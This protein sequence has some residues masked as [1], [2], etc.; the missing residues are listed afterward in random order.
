M[1]FIYKITRAT[2]GPS[3]LAKV[4][5]LFKKSSATGVGYCR[6]YKVGATVPSYSVMAVGATNLTFSVVVEGDYGVYIVQFKDDVKEV[7]LSNL[8]VN[9]FTAGS[10]DNYS[11][12]VDSSLTGVTFK[13]VNNGSSNLMYSIDNGATFKTT[14]G[15]SC[16]FTNAEILSAGQE[17]FISQ[18][19]VKKAIGCPGVEHILGS[20][21]VLGDIAYSDM[22]VTPTNTQ[23]T[24]I[25]GN[26]GTI[27]LA[28]TG[29]SGN[30][31]YS[32]ADGPTVQN[33]SGLVAG[34]YVVTVTDITTLEVVVLNIA[35]TDPITVTEEGSFIEI[36]TMNSIT[37]VVTSVIDGCT[38]PQGLDNV[39][40]CEQVYEGFDRV[41]YFQ[42]F[43]KC[44]IPVTQI[45][46]DFNFFTVSLLKYSDNSFVKA[47]IAELKEQNIGVTEDF[48]ITIRD[49]TEAN[50]SRVYFNAGA[51]PIPLSAGNVFEILNNANGYNG[52]YAILDIITDPTLGYQYLVITK[53]FTG[54]G[55]YQTGTGRFLS[56]TADFN[57][58]EVV[59]D[60]SD[61]DEGEYYL[62]VYAQ[63]ET[64]L[65]EIFAYSEPLDIRNS[66]PGT[67]LVKYRNVDNAFDITWTTGYQGLI[68]VPSHFGHRRSPG[69]ERTVNRN[70]DYK[71]VKV[72]AKK[73]RVL[74]FQVWSLPPY[75]HEKLSTIFDCDNYTL[76][77]I[78]CQT[79][80][81]YGE[82]EYKD[83]F[84]LADS[85]IKIEAAWYDRY[86]S[87]DLGSVSDGGFL[88]TET[89]FIK[90]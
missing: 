52:N 12:E 70:S 65:I 73:T 11:M 8:E 87:N 32:W 90:R 54:P 29:G 50:K 62:Q 16:F 24:F 14:A 5:L 78:E 13:N 34:D 84:L 10:C 6:I 64:S 89:G 33:R 31:T 55:L 66:Q 1:R 48:G 82:P 43:N 85:S 9:S 63:N 19:I 59:H 58:F 28:I 27:T 40:L 71:L 47:F 72:S 30:R 3:F 83:R 39:L 38:N 44:D 21:I 81:G 41:N 36:P 75:M 26:D 2:T 60:F 25:G 18:V 20:A 56:E 69:G 68:R 35:I 45:N 74:L 57:V 76:N 49:H 61:V 17:N 46:T 88:L 53:N 80:E 86:N 79:S 23:T 7:V 15:S 37:F 77:N 51:L 4:N 42:K 67:T 22:V